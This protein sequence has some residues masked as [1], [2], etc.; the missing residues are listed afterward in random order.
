MLLEH[1]GEASGVFGGGFWGICGVFWIIREGSWGI[2]G[3]LMGNRGR[4]LEYSGK[5]VGIRG[6]FLEFDR[7]LGYSGKQ[8]FRLMIRN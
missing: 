5:L 8:I 2:R 6:G 1:S 3:K 7:L 4:L